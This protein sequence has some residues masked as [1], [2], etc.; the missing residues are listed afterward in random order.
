MDSTCAIAFMSVIIVGFFW[1][2]VGSGIGIGSRED[3]NWTM[4]YMRQID[5]EF[6]DICTY[7]LHMSPTTP[8]EVELLLCG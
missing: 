4:R 7:V 6:I 5:A 3:D 8:R 1:P 2:L